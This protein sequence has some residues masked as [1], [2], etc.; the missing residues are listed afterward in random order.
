MKAHLSRNPRN[1][2]NPRSPEGN[3]AG[4]TADRLSPDRFATLFQQSWRTL[5]CIGIAVIGKQDEVD[6][7]L[8]ESAVI[9]LGKLG[10]FDPQTSFVAWMGQIVRYT[11]LNAGRR[12]Q[13]RSSTHASGEGV[14][15]QVPDM[16]SMATGEHTQLSGRGELPDDQSMFDDR[17][18][19]AMERLNETARAC[20]LLRVVRELSYRDIALALDI[21]EGTAMS[22]VHRA[23]K[24]LREAMYDTLSDTD[25]HSS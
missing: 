3:S 23:H 19:G 22:H 10:E 21:P 25:V 8:Q 7:V 5:W 11:A 20:V 1:P 14:L 2:R 9:A 24:A 15:E 4:T 17:L 12:R 13:R 6:D 16:P 18:L